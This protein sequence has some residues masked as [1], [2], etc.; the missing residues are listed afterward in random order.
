[1]AEVS[2][3]SL[4]YL[5][6]GVSDLS[7]WQSYAT[8]VLG[9]AC[10]A[11]DGALELR[12]DDACW[13]I[14]LR[15]DDA[16]D[17]VCAGYEVADEPTL[18][19]LGQRLE[20]QGMAVSVATE[21]QCQARQVQAMLHCE[22][23]FGLAV[24]LYV[25]ARRAS[26]PLSLPI[27][28]TT[29]VTAGQGLGHMVLTVGEQQVAERFYMDAL[30]FRLSDHIFMGPPGRQ[31]Q[32][33]FLHCNPRHHTVALAPV[34]APKRLNHIMLQVSTLDAVGLGLDRA[35][36][37][38]VPMAATLGKHTNDHMIS[39]YMRTPS[40]FDVEYGFGGIEVDDATWQTGT[41]HATSFWGHQRSGHA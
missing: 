18:Q 27:D 31:V 40:G 36:A 7:A 34:P 21:S 3:R 35:Q 37:A 10:E 41:H 11:V 16:D 24:E 8:E 2:V 13:R 6:L 32:L 30:G 20:A 9:V 19:A 5:E 14:R 4:G 1:M 22:D 38:G 33:T 17:I 15:Q 29:F 12:Y 39:F 23:P 26:Q 28:G 25:G